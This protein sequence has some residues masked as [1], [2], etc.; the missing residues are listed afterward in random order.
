[1]RV[2]DGKRGGKR[3]LLGARCTEAFKRRLVRAAQ[4]ADSTQAAWI[5][6]VLEEA[7]EAAGDGPG[8]R[9]EELTEMVFTNCSPEFKRRAARAARAQG[10]TLS[11]WM[12][13]ELSKAMEKGKT[14]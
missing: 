14:R 11:S 1:M 13:W 9:P 6:A 2:A 8:A 3:A 10:R 5:L 7:A 12:L 4:A